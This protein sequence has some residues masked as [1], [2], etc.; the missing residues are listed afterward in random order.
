[1]MAEIDTDRQLVARSVNG[2]G[3]VL[4]ACGSLL[5]QAITNE[6]WPLPA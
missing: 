2:A 1:M 6:R 3:A 5:P 4:A